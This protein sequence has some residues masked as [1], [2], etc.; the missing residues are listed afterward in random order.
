MSEKTYAQML[1]EIVPFQKQEAFNS[2][3]SEEK[4]EF[5][6]REVLHSLMREL[7]LL[8]ECGMKKYVFH[9][10]ELRAT[11]KPS[12]GDCSR[13]SRELGLKCYYEDRIVS[14]DKPYGD[15]YYAAFL[16]VDWSGDDNV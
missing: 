5:R 6:Y 1:R 12:A 13:I 10:S 11:V 14:S 4:M 2:L 15:P 16:V 8:A 9:P 7:E 3:S